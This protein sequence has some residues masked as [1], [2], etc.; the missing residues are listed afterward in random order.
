MT[1]TALPGT[2]PAE[3]A[4]EREA[5]DAPVRPKASRD[6][7]TMRL[8]MVVIGLYLVVAIAIPLGSVLLR[9]FQTFA[10]SLSEL[11]IDV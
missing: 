8:L 11:E 4:V 6:D 10:F 9:S 3:T 7:W 5:P 1:A 2:P